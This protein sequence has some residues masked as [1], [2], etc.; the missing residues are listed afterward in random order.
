VK[1]AGRHHAIHEFK[2]TYPRFTGPHPAGA[3][4]IR[5]N[6]PVTIQ[7]LFANGRDRPV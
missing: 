2:T 3:E 5:Y 6:L 1:F 7:W 4:F